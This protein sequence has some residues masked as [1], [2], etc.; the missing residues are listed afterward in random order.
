MEPPNHDVPQAFILR[1]SHNSESLMQNISRLGSACINLDHG[2]FRHCIQSLAL[3]SDVTPILFMEA[4]SYDE[5][6]MIVLH[7]R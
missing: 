2:P 3:R 4:A 5:T 1:R 6:P 7:D